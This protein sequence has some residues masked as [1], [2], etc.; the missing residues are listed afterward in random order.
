MT[1]IKG[2]GMQYRSEL[3]ARAMRHATLG[4]FLICFGLLW[5]SQASAEAS[6]TCPLI[7]ASVASGGT[8]VIDVSDCDGPFDGGMSG[9]IAP[10]A[11]QGKVQIGKNSDG[12]Q[13]VTYSH[14]GSSAANDVF[15]LEDN[16]NGV[17]TVKITITKS[18]ARK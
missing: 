16:E 5:A 15:Y 12:V 17:V 2:Q 8:I 3:K 1:L 14:N 13:I 7:N 18:K 9:P 11:A 4:F 10:H 6:T